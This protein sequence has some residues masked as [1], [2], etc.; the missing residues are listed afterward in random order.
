MQP[1]LEVFTGGGV[2]GLERIQAIDQAVETEQR[3]AGFAQLDIKQCTTFPLLLETAEERA[4]QQLAD[5]PKRLFSGDPAAQA[6][7]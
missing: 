5:G 3:A 2:I 6:E 4:A 1:R 7:A